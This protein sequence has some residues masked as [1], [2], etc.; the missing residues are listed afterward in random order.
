MSAQAAPGQWLQY[1][2]LSPHFRA[3]LPCPGTMEDSLGGW[4]FPPA[5]FDDVSTE[6]R[7]EWSMTALSET[8][9]AGLLHHELTQT[10]LGGP[11]GIKWGALLLLCAQW[12]F[13]QMRASR[14]PPQVTQLPVDVKAK[15]N[16]VAQE[17]D[18]LVGEIESSMQMLTQAHAKQVN[19]AWTT[20][21]IDMPPFERAQPADEE[22]E[23][24]GNHFHLPSTHTNVQQGS[25]SAKSEQKPWGILKSGKSVLRT[26]KQRVVIELPCRTQYIPHDIC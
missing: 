8:L 5:Y 4:W 9:R 26:T 6:Q 12:C 13:Q 1:M 17:V 25:E 11:F 2:A 23:T 24:V 18:W 16:I 10:C 20:V 7:V 3:A 22:G 15:A 19:R 21:L 14:R